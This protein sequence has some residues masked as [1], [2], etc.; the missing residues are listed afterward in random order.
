HRRPGAGQHLSSSLSAPASSLSPCLS[1]LWRPP[2]LRSG[3]VPLSLSLSAP[4]FSLSPCLSPL[5]PPPSLPVSLRSGAR[6]QVAPAHLL[7]IISS[8]LDSKR[9]ARL[10]HPFSSRGFRVAAVSPNFATIFKG[11]RL[12][13]PLSLSPIFNAIGAQTINVASGNW[14]RLNNAMMVFDKSHPLLYHFI[15]EFTQ[16]FDGNRWGHNGPYLVLRVASRVARRPSSLP[17]SLHSGLLPLAL[18]LSVASDDRVRNTFKKEL[19]LWQTLRHPNI[20][21]FLGVLNHPDRLIFLTESLPNGSLFD[22]LRRK[23]RLDIATAVAYALDIARGMNYL[24][25]HKP[26]AIVHRDLTLRNVLQ[27]EAGRLKVTDFGLSKI[28]QEKDVYRYKMTGGTGSCD[29]SF[30]FFNHI[31]THKE[32][33]INTQRVDLLRF[34][35]YA[36]QIDTWRQRFTTES[37]MERVWMTSNISEAP[38]AVADRRAYEDSRPSLSSYVYPDPIKSLLPDCW[39]KEPVSRPSFEGI[40]TKVDE[41]QQ[42]LETTKN[43]AAG[44]CTYAILASAFANR[45]YN[46]A[47]ATASRVLQLS[48]VMG[49]CLAAF[50]GFGLQF[51]WRLFTKDVQV[52]KLMR[53]GIPFVAATQPL[54]AMAFVFDGINPTKLIEIL[55]D[56]IVGIHSTTDEHFEAIIVEWRLHGAIIIDEIDRAIGRCHCCFMFSNTTDELFNLQNEE[57]F[58]R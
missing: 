8:S 51:A 19:T 15:K 53:I 30:T 44:C 38:E 43:K 37:H 35:W 33:E 12:Q 6:L 31:L 13:M 47:I 7:L 52:M 55:G 21:Q 18:S 29:K 4:A 54:N 57:K 25:Q 10:L 27:D 32:P 46:K 49:L 40:I 2:S 23:R 28:A 34:L 42:S 36:E 11:A 9:G 26:H 20:V 24:H 39:H 3:L 16:T 1:P 5:R 56:A 45:D 14:S 58:Q 50:L 48:V 41:I 22:I 17:V